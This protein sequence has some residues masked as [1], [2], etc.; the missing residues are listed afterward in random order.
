MDT[1]VNASLYGALWFLFDHQGR[2]PFTALRAE[3]LSRFNLDDY[4]VLILP[5]DSGDGRDY[6]RIISKNLRERIGNWIRGGGV[7]IGIKGGAVFAT[8]QK[9][10]WA[11]VGYRYVRKR[12]EERRLVQERPPEPQAKAL[13]PQPPKLEKERAAEELKRKMLRWEEKEEVERREE[14]PGTIMRLKI[15][16]SHPLGFGYGQEVHVL[17]DTSP[18]LELSDDGGDNVIYYPEKDFKTSGFLSAENAGKLSH[19]AYLVREGVGRGHV[20]LFADTPV[21]RGFWDGTIR[22]LF[23]SIFFGQVGAGGRRY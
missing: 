6:D 19:T 21:F 10:G 18:I 2:L 3:E 8:R 23:N 1:P 7:L 5:P 4:N 15:D 17:N 12:D 14:I 9:A 11:S 22:L 16:N 20:V 13:P